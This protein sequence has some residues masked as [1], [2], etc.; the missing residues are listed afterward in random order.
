MNCPSP[1]RSKVSPDQRSS[2]RYTPF[3]LLFV[4]Y[5]KW[6]EVLYSKRVENDLLL[7]A[8]FLPQGAPLERVKNGFGFLDAPSLRCASLNKREIVK[9]ILTR[10]QS[11]P[12]LRKIFAV[13]LLFIS[14]RRI[15]RRVAASVIPAQTGMTKKMTLQS[16]RTDNILVGLSFDRTFYLSFP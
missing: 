13:D 9:V 14:F 7:W 5:S 12:L 2:F 8:Y 4:L 16:S 6:V 11:S 15:I 1:K 10:F 3:R